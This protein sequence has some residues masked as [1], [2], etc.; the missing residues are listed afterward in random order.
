MRGGQQEQTGSSA[1]R[2]LL[3]P[4]LCSGHCK[5]GSLLTFGTQMGASSEPCSVKIISHR[6]GDSCLSKKKKK[7]KQNPKKSHGFKQKPC[8]RTDDGFPSSPHPL[9]AGSYKQGLSEQGGCISCV[10][11]HNT[12]SVMTGCS[13]ASQHKLQAA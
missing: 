11:A 1:V 8:L 12:V 4:L 9:L 6:K 5:N 7:K 2:P 13:V 10:L 3:F